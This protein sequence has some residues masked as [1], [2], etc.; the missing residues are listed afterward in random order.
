MNLS[1]RWCSEGIFSSLILI[2]SFIENG[3]VNYIRFLKSWTCFIVEPDV[4]YSRKRSWS[5]EEENKS[6]LSINISSKR[7]LVSFTSSFEDELTLQ[8]QISR[9]IIQHFGNYQG[10]FKELAVNNILYISD[11]YDYLIKHQVVCS[12]NQLI[13]LLKPYGTSMVYLTIEEFQKFINDLTSIQISDK[14]VEAFPQT[15]GYST[16]ISLTKDTTKYIHEMKRIINSV[17]EYGLHR[18]ASVAQNLNSL[19]L[20]RLMLTLNEDTFQPQENDAI[21]V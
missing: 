20:Y 15:F 7:R 17:G 2:I 21:F 12:Y 3:N 9:L 1:F 5:E 16:R 10:I 4:C 6:S 11:L 8:D 18:T 14:L 13:L 19:P